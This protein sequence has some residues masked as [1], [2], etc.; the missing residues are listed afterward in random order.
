MDRSSPPLFPAHK[1]GLFIVAILALL[2]SACSSMNTPVADIPATETSPTTAPQEASVENSFSPIEFIDY[3]DR[4]V[5]IDALPQRIVSLAPSVSE[6]LFA[7]GAGPLMVGRTDYCN[8]PPEVETLPSIGGFAA[9]SISIET[10]LDLE[11]D[12]VIGGSTYQSEVIDALDTAGITAFVVQPASLD[13]IKKTI[14]LLGTITDHANDAQIIIDDMQT[15]IDAVTI[16]VTEIPQEEK[17]R[18]FYE[19]WHEPLMTT[20]HKT[21]IGEIIEL[22]GGVNIFNDLNE[23]YPS[24]SAEQIIASDPQ[25]IVGPSNHADQLTAEIISQ[26]EGWQDI[27]A[28]KNESVY[29]LDGDIVSRPAPR[30]IEALE[31][32]AAIL[33]PE[34]IN[35]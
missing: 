31:E 10:I 6:T 24:I 7:I 4:D 33:Y 35:E 28:V 11:P 32:M 34:M 8:Y 30:I 9:S 14:L 23:Q 16:K 3:L 20:T 25:V 1:A 5:S 26:R 21:F 17:P 29:I 12:I 22:A 27:S 18:V 19:V 15:R 2:L 13:E